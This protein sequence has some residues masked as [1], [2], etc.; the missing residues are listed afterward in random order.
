VVGRPTTSASRA[1]SSRIAMSG[2]PGSGTRRWD[3][4][5]PGCGS[6][7]RYPLHRAVAQ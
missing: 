3:E 2:L 7:P 4:A 1:V 5:Q 6:H